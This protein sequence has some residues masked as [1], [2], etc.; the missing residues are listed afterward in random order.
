[1]R[2]G[3]G[4]RT[5]ASA[6]S[7]ARRSSSPRSPRCRRSGSATC[8]PSRISGSRAVS[9]SWNTVEAIASAKRHQ[10]ALLRAD[11]LDAVEQD[12][13]G[14]REPV[15]QQAGERERGERLAGS[16]LADQ[17]EP[18][19]RREAERHVVNERRAVGGRHRRLLH[20]RTRA[21][22]RIRAHRDLLRVGSA[23][24]RSPS[25]TRLTPITSTTS[26]TP[27]RDRPDGRGGHGALRLL[28]QAAPGRVRRRGAEAEVRQARLGEHGD[29]EL[30]RQVHAE[31]RPDVR[32]GCAGR[33][34]PATTCP[35]SAP[36]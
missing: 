9:G 28:Q 18:L 27:G 17:A 21:P 8:R 20:A 14:C 31:R 36:R 25:A 32:A 34:C 30:Q 10:V 33:R 22:A 7:T 29:A 11:H 15:G 19:P 16:R 5:S 2:S 4:S 23:T 12:A 13:A 24:S 6:S 26:A 1:M 3:S 35:R